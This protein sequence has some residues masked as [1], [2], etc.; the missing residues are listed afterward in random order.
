V[1]VVEGVVSTQVVVG[2][3]SVTQAWVE[4]YTYKRLGPQRV[5]VGG[6]W[7]TAFCGVAL[8]WVLHLFGVGNQLTR[9]AS[10]RG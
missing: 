8:A 10:E 3:K 7:H 2:M 1:V 4:C 9:R 5:V 6:A